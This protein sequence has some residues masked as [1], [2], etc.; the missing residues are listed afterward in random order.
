MAIPIR[1]KGCGQI[2]MWYTGAEGDNRVISSTIVYLDGTRPAFG[3]AAPKC[4][5]CGGGMYPGVNLIR[6]FD[7]DVDP[8][9]DIQEAQR[10]GM[11][12]NLPPGPPDPAKVAE[13]MRNRNVARLIFGAVIV[14]YVVLVIYL[15]LGILAVNE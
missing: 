15:V 3:S 5:H 6:C 9:F 4:P 14:G 1:H 2:A 11:R 12:V 8:G 7:E 10:S 13:L